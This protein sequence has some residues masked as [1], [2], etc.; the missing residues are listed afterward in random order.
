MLNRGRRIDPRPKAGTRSRSNISGD[1][2]LLNFYA[3]GDFL[4]S[5]A[6]V[7]LEASAAPVH[8]VVDWAWV[9][10]KAS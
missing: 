4:L 8:L 1:S 9:S 3:S 6:G 2:V 5:L 7:D 10:P